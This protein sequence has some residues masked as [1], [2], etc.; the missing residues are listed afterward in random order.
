MFRIAGAELQYNLAGVAAWLAVLLVVA[1]WPLLESGDLSGVP[2]VLVMMSMAL[3]LIAPVSCFLLINVERNER[4]DRL[5][6]MLPL[7]PVT[8]A[9]AR[10][11]RAA[12]VP[13][14]ALAIGTLLTLLAAMTMGAALFERLNGAWVLLFLLLAALAV[15][16]LVTLL[17][18][19]GGM[20]FAQLTTAMLV[21]AGF[22]LNSFVPAF[23]ELVAQITTIAQTLSGVL[24]M[25]ATLAVLL[26]ADILVFVR[27]RA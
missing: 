16:T 3:P 15:G 8:I 21:A 2:G 5:W 10:L 20:G 7:A 19:I 4:R 17:Y 14:L 22:M 6:R 11:V 25:A 9:A 12:F 24:I 27:K 1:G 18:D 26:V 13:A 23:T